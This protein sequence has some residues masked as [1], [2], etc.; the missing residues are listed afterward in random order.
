MEN[1]HDFLVWT[2]IITGLIPILLITYIEFGGGSNILTQEPRSDYSRQI[3]NQIFLM[4]IVGYGL[5]VTIYAIYFHIKFAHKDI[6]LLAALPAM[7]Y[8]I[9]VLFMNIIDKAKG[10]IVQLKFELEGVS[11]ENIES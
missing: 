7:A 4:L 10:R 11:N 1:F 3:F 8:F 2:L 5:F 6:T 9:L